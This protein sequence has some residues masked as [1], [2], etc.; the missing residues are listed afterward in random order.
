MSGSLNKVH[1][2][3]NLGQDPRV[4]LTTKGNKVAS[5]SVATSYKYK[6][7]ETGEKKEITEW[8]RV[9]LFNR[10]AEVVEEFLKKGM[11]VYVEGYLRTR[12]YTDK[13]G[14]ERYSTEIVAE[15]MQMLYSKPGGDS[16]ADSVA[17]EAKT[18]NAEA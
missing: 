7:A 4:E 14:V 8:H 17:G 10:L 15:S 12:K 13:D 3:G 6:D 18:E 2:I 9:V 16:W 1:L 11:S 5:I